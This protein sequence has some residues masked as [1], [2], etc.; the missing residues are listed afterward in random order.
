MDE[1]ERGKSTLVHLAQQ[2]TQAE[3]NEA[4]TRRDIIDVLL[5][6]GLGWADD[7]ITCE[8][9]DESG[10]YF[11]YAVGKPDTRFILEAK[12]TSITF[13]VP[14]GVNSGIHSIR[15]IYD[16]SKR[17]AAAIDQVLRYCQESGVGIAVLSNGLQLLIFLGSRS[18]G[19][20]PLDGKAVFF[21]SLSSMADSFNHL[22]DSI[23]PAGI[24][25]GALNRA[26]NERATATAPDPLSAHINSYPG[27]RIG[28]EMETDLKILGDL[29]IQDVTHEDKITDDFLLECY[30]SSGALSQYSV[31]SKEILKTRYRLLGEQV[32][33]ET[34]RNQKGTNAHLTE[35]ILAGSLTKRPIILL[36]DVGVGKSLFLKHLFRIEAKELLTSTVIFYIDFLNNSGLRDDI[37]NEI[38]QVIKATLQDK[39]N[40][41]IDESTFIRKIYRKEI[42][43]FKQSIYGEL[44]DVDPVEFKR[45]ELQMLSG[46]IDNELEH[47]KRVLEFLQSSRRLNF[48]LALDNVDQHEATFQERIFVVGQSLADRWPTAVFISLR[49][50]TF[51]RS[52][53]SGALAA[54]QPR[55]FTVSPPRCDLVVVKRLQFARKQLVEAGRLP[56]FPSGLTLNSNSLLVYIDVLLDA[57]E[58]NEQLI[59]LVDNLSSGN[60]RRALDFISTFVGSGY[61]Q[62]KRI[63]DAHDAGD[64]YVI[65]IHEFIRAIL[66]GEHKYYDPQ[67]SSVP[68]I[69]H[70][71]S[72]DP[73][74]YFLLLL[75]LAKIEEL[76]ISN[77]GYFADLSSV[78]A[79][80]QSLGYSSEQI[81]YHINRAYEAKLI[82]QN[83][84]GDAGQLV[85]ITQAGSYLRKKMLTTFSY[86]D[87]VIVDTPI[88]DVK[89][90]SQI[91]DVRSIAERIKRA[92]VFQEYLDSCWPFTANEVSLDWPTI[93]QDW[94]SAMTEVKAGASRAE[95][96]RRQGT[97]ESRV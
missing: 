46:L 6:D 65:P 83:D 44:E 54:Y 17:S 73:K 31:I 37:S 67:T 53:K 88:L 66:Y 25:N 61:V 72:T 30:C 20:K 34:A 38:V 82:E 5:R 13:D 15:T 1:F 97:A 41:D 74:E 45:K 55:V 64:S 71:L 96:R 8:Q 79:D 80:I 90:R 57:F 23:S 60:T 63:I 84:S 40:V 36:G 59:E 89:V 68:N 62:T 33:A 3:L 28:T 42:Q 18:D 85:R 14:A 48:V 93:Y 58:H 21:D 75:L 27:Y 7:Q 24:I 2:Y 52:R 32:N 43:Q 86:I 22:W 87:A 77:E 76:G 81:K 10:D 39:T 78:V 56:G 29:F 35:D 94:K 47:T 51:Y 49:P 26:L 92:E 50:D 9:Y 91:R 4:T 12:K 11:D 69:F 16:H 95:K 19:R 70:I